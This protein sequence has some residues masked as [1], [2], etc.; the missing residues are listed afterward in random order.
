MKKSFAILVLILTSSVL[1]GCLFVAQAPYIHKQQKE[2]KANCHH[3]PKLTG[4]HFTYCP[5]TDYAIIKK[6]MREYAVMKP[7]GELTPYYHAIKFSNHHKGQYYF[8]IQL[9][10]QIGIMNLDGKIILPPDNYHALTFEYAKGFA[11]CGTFG[12]IID[13]DHKK[14]CY[15]ENGNRAMHY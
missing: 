15:D 14:V 3:F 4:H 1:S 9:G 13:K 6:G 11:I 2:S 12:N 7:S 5:N 8:N 10:K